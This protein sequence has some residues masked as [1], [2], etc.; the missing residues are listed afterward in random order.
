LL[1]EFFKHSADHTLARLESF[2]G[3]VVQHV[4]DACSNAL[5]DLDTTLCGIRNGILADEAA[6]TQAKRGRCAQSQHRA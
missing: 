3:E 1:Q 5:S 2:K 6:E 4:F